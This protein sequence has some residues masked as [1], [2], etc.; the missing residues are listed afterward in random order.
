MHGELDVRPA[1]LHPDLP[2]AGD[3]R[4]PHA[5]VFPVRQSL[6]R[7]HG[8]RVS[9]MDAHRVQVLDGADDDDVVPAVPHHLQLVFLP[10]G[11]GLLDQ[12]LGDHARVQTAR[13]HV[14]EPGPVGDHPA[15]GTAEGEGGP[16]DQREADRLRD[17]AGL[18]EGMGEPAP[19]QVDPDPLHGLLEQLAVF[20]LADG[21]SV[22][23]D[24]PHAHPVEDAFL[25][26]LDGD[27]QTR[28][29]AEGG[30]ESVRTLGLDDLFQH[31]NGDR[32]DV[33]GV[34]HLGIRH[35]GRGVRVD[36]DDAHPLFP[37]RLAGLG[38]GVVE[39]ACLADDDGAGADDED[40]MDVSSSGHDP[41]CRP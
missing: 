8:D 18:L 13:G 9:R 10:A 37:Q 3:R 17:P 15:S 20:C 27:V 36:Q 31:G 22:R 26:E 41:A 33:R 16:D 12:D 29:P 7:S 1:G 23:A 40:R 24:H 28:L 11:D 6:G 21:L 30:Q 32:L 2:D 35:D 25:R 39:L 19:R 4:V 38:P 14:F 34:R 5:L